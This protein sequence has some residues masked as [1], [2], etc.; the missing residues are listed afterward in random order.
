MSLDFVLETRCV[1][2][3]CINRGRAWY[4]GCRVNKNSIVTGVG[5][6]WDG[7]PECIE[8]GWPNDR[9]AAAVALTPE[10]AAKVFAHRAKRGWAAA[11]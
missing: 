9:T 6:V 4:S 11:A 7:R 8:C 5:L 2:C 3:G 10:S 1:A